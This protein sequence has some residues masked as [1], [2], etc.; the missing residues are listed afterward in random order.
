MLVGRNDERE[1]IGELVGSDRAAVVTGPPGIGKTTLARSALADRGPFRE[2]GALATL[3]W[4]PLL[5]FRRL[6]GADP[7]ELA[8]AVAAAV[9]HDGSSPLLL[10]DLQWADDASLEVVAQL[11]GRVPMVMTVRTGSDRS[12]LVIEALTL[13]GAERIDLPALDEDLAARLADELH[14]DLSAPA[15]TQLLSAAAGNPLLLTELPNGP[16][17]APSLVGALVARA[18]L[19]SIDGRRAL[20]RLAVLG[21]PADLA[22]LGPGAPELVEQG[23]A[24]D[25]D[26][27]Y[28]IT[29][30]L[31]AE[32]LV[33][34]LGDRGDAVRRELADL[35]GPAEGAHLLAVAGDRAAARSLALSAARDGDRRRRATLLALAVSCA[36]DLDAPNRIRAARLFTSV[37]EP[38]RARELCTPPG[39]DELE[40]VERGALRAAEA[41]AAWLQG[42]QGESSALVELALVDLAG[43]RTPYEV[44]VLAGSTVAQT[45]VDLDGRPA[46]ERARAAVRLADE[47][48][49]EQGYARSRLASVLMTSGEPGWADLYQEVIDLAQADED[50]DLR[51]TAVVSLALGH[52]ATG[53]VPAAEAVAR[54]EM[55]AGPRQAFDVTWLTMAS[56]AAVLG[57]VGGRGRAELVDE[58]S[59]ILDRWE[60]FRSRPF[61]GAAVVLTLADGG[62]QPAALERA[63]RCVAEASGD[64]Q[65]RS[66]ALWAL[67]ET[68]WLAGRLD[69]VG[70]VVDSVI[71][72]GVGDYPSA[73]LARLIVAHTARELSG[74][75]IGHGP[76]AM[77]P[78]WEPLP[79]EWDAVRAATSGDDERAVAGLVA[80]ADGWTPLDVR[81]EVRCRWAAGD[82][83]AR[84]V[85]PEAVTLLEVAEARALELGLVAMVA[86]IHRSLRSIGISRRSDIGPG[87]VGL[88]GREEQVLDLVGSGMRST[89]IAAALGIEVSTVE[90]YVRSAMQKLGTGTRSAAAARLQQL[91]GR[92]VSEDAPPPSG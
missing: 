33:D 72:L 64:G 23:L 82:V 20:A 4:S 29:H 2:G 65:W 11:M 50:D 92:G 26:E 67:A 51:R 5:V 62:R 28:A 30:S 52:W 73:A 43:T 58:F 44:A 22:V 18:G 41:E 79:T 61:L 38:E 70:E 35:V 47:I 46:L 83:A 7:P 9:L 39:L 87:S 6:L 12:D 89:E 71:A 91:R 78:A 59:P 21:R 63:T 75:V 8:E 15:R 45:F 49:A 68:R 48:G 27:A 17:A 60:S 85:R 66:I 37:S 14:P 32:V 84:A 24:V 80:A 56:Y 53:D 34:D 13:V 36:P 69:E 42:R 1:L 40:P 10:D 74:P 88:T 31:L 25:P 57:L 19:L 90:T 55:E 16:S 77:L 54:A 86:R 81:S 76:M 3:A